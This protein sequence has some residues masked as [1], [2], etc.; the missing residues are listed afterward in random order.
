MSVTTTTENPTMEWKSYKVGMD[1]NFGCGTPMKL[2]RWAMVQVIPGTEVEIW[3]QGKSIY[4]RRFGNDTMPREILVAVKDVEPYPNCNFWVDDRF[5]LPKAGIQY[6]Q[7]IE[8]RT[9]SSLV[10]VNENT[11]MDK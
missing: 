7:E 2:M 3:F 1:P 8:M 10:K 4:E 5:L 9:T 11:F 6:M